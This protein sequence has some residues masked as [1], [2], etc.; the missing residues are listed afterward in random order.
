VRDHHRAEDAAQL[1]F[2]TLARKAHTIRRGRCVAAWLHRVAYRQALRQRRLAHRRRER[3]GLGV[4]RA[5]TTDA[6]CWRRIERRYELEL[7]DQELARLPANYRQPLVLHYLLGRSRKETAETLGLD[8][9]TVKGRLQRGRN[10]L[11]RRL[12]SRGVSCG[13]VLALVLRDVQSAQLAAAAHSGMIARWSRPALVDSTISGRI[14]PRFSL[15]SRSCIMP[16]VRLDAL[17]AAAAALTVLAG[18]LGLSLCFGTTAFP[19]QPVHVH[20]ASSALV[21]PTFNNV[22]IPAVAVLQLAQATQPAAAPRP[23]TLLKY[24]DQ[25]PDGRKSIAG[26]GEMIR[27]ELP[28]A[29]QRVRAI[30][31]HGSRYG[32]P[33]PPAEDFEILFL[34]EDM[35][36][37]LH[38]QKAP[39]SLFQ[40]GE[41]KWVTVRFD[42][43][44]PVSKVFWVL[45]NFNAERTKG[46]YVSYDNSTS[47][48]HSRV[49]LPPDQPAQEAGIQGDWMI[50]AVLTA[51]PL[52]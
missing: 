32:Y 9:S 23:A 34:N 1:T 44:L 11:R 14:D 51:P 24:S 10:Q 47:G 30:K 25:K 33:R 52:P 2:Q 17:T 31:I 15:T 4:D 22:A 20:Q 5:A 35:S 26:S 13:V 43:P 38:E 16:T 40:R 37:V 12:A 49:G 48:E 3:L 50:E 21:P 42:K 46:V 29:N 27:F 7:L 6:D 19:T 28:D 41:A 8:E 39:Y 18:G 36:E 45:V